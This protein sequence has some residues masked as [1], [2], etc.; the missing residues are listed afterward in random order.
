[1]QDTTGLYVQSGESI[2][3]GLVPTTVTWILHKVQRREPG[4]IR[5]MPIC[6]RCGICFCRT[7]RHITL[8]RT[9]AKSFR[10]VCS[11]L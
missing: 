9:G 8:K 1:M 6:Q 2:F 11:M 3:S 5:V 10:S 4:A 7:Q